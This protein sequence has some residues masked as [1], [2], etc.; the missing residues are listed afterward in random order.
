MNLD[1]INGRFSRKKTEDVDG[2][3]TPMESTIPL[4]ETDPDRQG[5]WADTGYS[6]TDEEAHRNVRYDGASSV[7]RMINVFRNQMKLFSKNKWVFILLFAAVLIPAIASILPMGMISA[8]LGTDDNSAQYM[9]LLL[10]MMPV[11][12]AFFTSVLCGTQIPQEFKDRTAYMSMPLPMTRLEF[13][14]GKY[15]AGFVLCLGVFLLAFGFATIMSMSKFDAFYSDLIGEALAVTIVCIFAYSATAFCLGCFMRR[16]STLVP[17]MLM[18]FILPAILLIVGMKYE[19]METVMLMP[20]FLPDTVLALLGS[21][22]SF[23]LS[24]IFSSMG[25]SPDM[26]NLGTMIVIGVVWGIMFLIV[27]ALQTKRREM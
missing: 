20:C 6:R 7:K 1:R 12:V 5:T 22:M 16:G 14:V 10:I 25:T 3:S 17:L 2:Q 26:S 19:C 23:S 13:Y 8:F 18:L 27:G 11:M 9:G 15:L 4:N 24:G 21:P